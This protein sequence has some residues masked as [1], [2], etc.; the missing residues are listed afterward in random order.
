MDLTEVER[1]AWMKALGQLDP[2]TN[3][4]LL[5]LLFDFLA[6]LGPS[7]RSFRV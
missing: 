4:P 6:I 2:H 7:K 3:Y 1:S 5:L